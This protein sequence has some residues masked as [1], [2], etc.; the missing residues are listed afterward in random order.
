MRTHMERGPCGIVPRFA[1][2]LAAVAMLAAC[3]SEPAQTEAPG[4]LLPPAPTTTPQA[5]PGTA[6]PTTAPPT[7]PGTAP[8]TKAAPVPPT[9]PGASPPAKAP[10]AAAPARPILPEGTTFFVH[11]VK[12]SGETVSIIAAWYL[13]DKMRFDVLTAANPDINPTLIKV[14]MKIKI[15][16]SA[17]K[18]HEAMTKEF[19]DSF[20]TRPGKE[21]APP[22]EPAK[23]EVPELIGPKESP[24]K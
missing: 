13:G 1:V 20:Y 21:K 3:A 8:P 23:E 18:K 5:A 12:F 16:E 24:P 11:T 19:V 10:P 9:G 15:P 14:G 6:P 7:A 17:M 22:S 2:T 4:Q